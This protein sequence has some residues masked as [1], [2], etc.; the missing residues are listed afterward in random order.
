MFLAGNVTNIVGIM[1]SVFVM[2][3]VYVWYRESRAA[4]KQAYLE[5][6]LMYYDLTH[7]NGPDD[8]VK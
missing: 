4:Y 8:S 7:P 1:F 2:W 3:F 6:N 5:Q